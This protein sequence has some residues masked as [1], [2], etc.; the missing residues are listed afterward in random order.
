MA[1]TVTGARRGDCSSDKA[2]TG[3]SGHHPDHHYVLSCEKKQFMD[4]GAKE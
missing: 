2:G 3:R 4:G 1:S